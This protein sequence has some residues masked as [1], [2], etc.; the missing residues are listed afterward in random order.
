MTA[1]QAFIPLQDIEKILQTSPGH[2]YWKDRDG[3]FLGCNQKQLTTL[4]MKSLD[5][6][7]GKTDF[8]LYS[9]ETATKVRNLDL[10]V[11]ERGK[12]IIREESGV[13]LGKFHTFLSHK[14]PTRD[15]EG[16]ITGIV[17]IS[18]DITDQKDLIESLQGKQKEEKRYK[19]TLRKI[20]KEDKAFLKSKTC[21]LPISVGQEYHE[22]EKLRATL[23]TVNASFKSCTIAVCDTLQRYSIRILKNKNDEESYQI[24]KQEGYEWIANHKK[25]IEHELQIP[26]KIIRW[27]HW[28][29]QEIFQKNLII[30]K[31]L[32]NFNQE[33][34][35]AVDQTV[36]QFLSRQEKLRDD[37]ELKVFFTQSLEYLFEEIAVMLQW[38]D[39]NYDYDLYPPTRNAALSK[40]FEI[41][42][43]N[44][45]KH[46]LVPAGI[47][48]IRSHDDDEAN[49][50]KFAFES[51]IQTM[52]GHVYWKNKHGMLLG[53][54][55]NNA[56]SFGLDNAESIIGKSDFDLFDYKEAL[57][58]RKNDLEVMNHSSTRITEEEVELAG[59]K[60]VYL[61]HKTPLKNASNQVIGI[62]GVSLDITRQKEI[63]AELIEKNRLLEEAIVAKSG[64]MNNMSHEIRTPVHGFMALSDGLAQHWDLFDENKKRMLA[65]QVADSA[66]RLGNLL[67]HLLDLAKFN[68]G[69]MI[70]TSNKFNLIDSVNNI[71]EEAKV[72]YIR[73]KDIALN[74]NQ[75]GSVMMHADAE[76][77][78]QVLRNIVT[79]AIKFSKEG[80]TIDIDLKETTLENKKAIEITIKDQG[81]GIPEA[82]LN[83]IFDPFVESSKTANKAGGT[84]L[85]LA[86]VREIV[87]LHHGKIFASNNKDGGASFHVIL[88]IEEASLG[89]ASSFSGKVHKIVMIDDEEMCLMGTDL[90][91]TLTPEFNLIKCNNGPN[92]LDY[93]RDH[94]DVDL[95]LLDLMMPG[96]NGQ[97]VLEEIKNDKRLS[98]IPVILQ[99]GVSDS[100]ELDKAKE[101]KL[102]AVLAKP[103]SCAQWID[104]LKQ[105]LGR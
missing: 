39:W 79:N 93:L 36:N 52:P 70:L 92:G 38:F 77:I 9:Q 26:Y 94:D 66:K 35:R 42:E 49:F 18:L 23:R 59:K 97:E 17:G 102:A 13:I 51:A 71:I 61:S 67:G 73:D 8:D 47:D 58:L 21:V 50:G 24:A 7:I 95:I 84:G 72:L 33:F 86:I 54:N 65:V 6:F 14:T 69:K 11:M 100:I 82:E 63:E 90:L 103:Y 5:E 56:K 29:Q 104:A 10:E 80:S 64:F 91:L 101:Y 85:G 81:I 20:A 12:T 105:V 15:N 75:T 32:Y 3:V 99:S 1:K 40:A 28:L 83:S 45:F 27:D 89:K 22:G 41:L 88:P 98:K 4:G 19:A 62:L 76:R 43:P 68:E 74:F 30:I 34:T 37:T 78:S 57:A 46:L 96:M 60:Y 87:T 55:L 53:S 48:F 44:K 2:I 31:E 25:I 16:N